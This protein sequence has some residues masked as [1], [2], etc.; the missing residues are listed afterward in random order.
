[1]K[2]LLIPVVVLVLA[3]CKEKKAAA[4]SDKIITE[5]KTQPSV[6]T[7]KNTSIVGKWVLSDANNTEMS[8]DDKKEL[9]GQASVEFAADG[10]YMSHAKEEGETGTYTYNEKTRVLTTTTN[11]KSLEEKVTAEVDGDKLTVTHEK[12]KGAMIFKRVTE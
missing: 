10:K 2:F 4:D 8:E 12:Q 9:I 5:E 3:S 6:E 7:E 1:M 11:E